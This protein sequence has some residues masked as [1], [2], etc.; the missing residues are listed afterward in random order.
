M[1]LSKNSTDVFID[2]KNCS[3]GDSP[4]NSTITFSTATPNTTAAARRH[5]LNAK[6]ETTAH[7][8]GHN[9]LCWGPARFRSLNFGERNGYLKGPTRFRSLNSGE[10][11]RYLKGV[12]PID[13]Q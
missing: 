13:A 1:I 9:H 10:R 7:A 8:D 6:G 5:R 2:T 3:H 11:N 12:A 4:T